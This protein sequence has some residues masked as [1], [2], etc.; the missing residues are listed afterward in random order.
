LSRAEFLR[1]FW[2][3]Y[4]MLNEG[5]T[6]GPACEDYAM[7]TYEDYTRDF[8]AHYQRVSLTP[9]SRVLV[10]NIPGFEDGPYSVGE[11]SF[12]GAFDE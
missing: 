6:D 5:M 11:P 9:G 4:R 2:S 7:P 3:E 12:I 8:M 1:E 10:V